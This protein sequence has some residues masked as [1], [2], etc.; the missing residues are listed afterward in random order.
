MTSTHAHHLALLVS[1]AAS[2]A[3]WRGRAGL[4]T[5]PRSPQGFLRTATSPRASVANTLAPSLA[6]KMVRLGLLDASDDDEEF[7]TA[8]SPYAAPTEADDSEDDAEVRARVRF[9]RGSWTCGTVENFG[10]HRSRTTR[11]SG[12]DRSG[13]LL[14]PP[15][16]SGIWESSQISRKAESVSTPAL[17]MLTLAAV[18]GST[19]G[20]TTFQTTWNH[21]GALQMTTRETRSG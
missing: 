14:E 3:N 17:T 9:R 10:H 2:S 15:N 7:T 13:S 11:R 12:S 20:L 16:D 4:A 6:A 1:Y 8:R 5:S 18:L 21:C 19:H